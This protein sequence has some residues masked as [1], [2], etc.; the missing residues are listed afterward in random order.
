MTK[1][2]ELLRELV[3]KSLQKKTDGIALFGNYLTMALSY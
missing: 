2:E 3:R 1:G